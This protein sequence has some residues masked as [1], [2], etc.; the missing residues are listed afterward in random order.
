MRKGGNL[1]NVIHTVGILLDRGHENIWVRRVITSENKSEQFILNC[2]DLW[3]TK[4]KIAEHY[5]FERGCEIN[6]KVTRKMQ[7]KYCG[8]PSQRLIVGIEGEVYPCCVDYEQ[9]MPLGK[10]GRQT[11]AQLWVSKPL[12]AL[13]KNLKLN[14]IPKGKQCADCTSFMAY[15][16]SE[17]DYVQDKEVI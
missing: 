17:R 4:V 12:E 14:N 15:D 9:S 2:R 8:Y 16:T 6:P 10:V 1:Q 3:G 13:R 5:C 11:L 7:R